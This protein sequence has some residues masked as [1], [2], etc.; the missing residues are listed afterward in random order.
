MCPLHRSAASHFSLASGDRWVGT[1]IARAKLD[2]PGRGAHAFGHAYARDFHEMGGR[3]EELQKSLGHSLIVVTEQ[4][5]GWLSANRAATLARARI[6]GE[7]L[8]LE[9]PKAKARGSSPHGSC[10]PRPAAAKRAESASN[11]HKIW[12]TSP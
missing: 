4:S 9:T 6:Y 8:T 10:R 3:L 7:R 12:H 1:I 5:H 11:R 2:K